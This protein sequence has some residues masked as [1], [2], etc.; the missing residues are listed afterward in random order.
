[1]DIAFNLILFVHFVALVVGTATNVAMPIVSRQAA[2]APPEAR[3]GFGAIG[4][5]LSLNARV[6]LALLVVSG[7]ILLQLRYG[8]V[9]GMNAWF[10]AKMVLVGTVIILVVVGTVLGPGRLNPRLFGA[11]TRL[12]LL[13]IILTAVFA[14]N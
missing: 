10:W 6:A 4:R 7:I 8:G 5:A 2:K 14:F 13:G 11:I 1:M 12:V 9:T 3:A